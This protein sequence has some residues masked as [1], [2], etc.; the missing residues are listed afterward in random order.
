[1]LSAAAPA[2]AKMY[3]VLAYLICFQRNDGY[4]PPGGV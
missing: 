2:D 4:I 3:G 1:M